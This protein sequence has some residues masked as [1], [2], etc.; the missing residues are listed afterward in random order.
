MIGCRR[1]CEF[2]KNLFGRF[3]RLQWN[4][5]NNEVKKRFNFPVEGRI[6][7]DG[8]DAQPF[9]FLE[10]RLRV[11]VVAHLQEILLNPNIKLQYQFII[12]PLKHQLLKSGFYFNFKFGMMRILNIWTRSVKFMRI[13][14]I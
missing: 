6:Q 3:L 14:F 4:D 7:L 13:G 1:C 5:V 2:L 11:I 9:S 10:E 8:E 12:K